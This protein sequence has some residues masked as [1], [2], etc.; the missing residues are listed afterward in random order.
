MPR[1]GHPQLDES[2]PREFQRIGPSAVRDVNA[3]FTGAFAFRLGNRLHD[4]GF[5]QFT[6]KLF[7]V[8]VPLPASTGATPA[9]TSATAG[10]APAGGPASAAP[11]TTTSSTPATAP[12]PPAAVIYPAAPMIH[13]APSHP[14]HVAPDQHQH[15]S[16]KKDE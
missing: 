14:T 9:K 12:P 13:G 1:L 16:P 2:F 10:K 15:A 4:S 6:D 3:N 7:V 8:H 5:V 11:A